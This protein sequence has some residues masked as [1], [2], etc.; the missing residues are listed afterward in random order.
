VDLASVQRAYKRYARHYDLL[1]GSIFDAGRRLSVRCVSGGGGRRILEVGVGT[2]LSL[3]YYPRDC[4]VVGVDV[5]RDMLEVARARAASERLH[6]VE[7]LLEMDAEQLD[8][9]DA[10]FDAVVAM[11]VATVVPDPARL[12]SEMCRVCVPGGDLVLVS[13]F[14]PERGPMRAVESALSPFSRVLGFRTAFTLDALRVPREVERVAV[15][16][17]NFLG[18]SKVVHYRR[19]ANGAPRRNGVPAR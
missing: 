3:R 17:V 14:A 10:S 19:T 1:W 11:Y 7:A 5:S 18:F 16:P 8:V 13:H 9:P 15:H 4:R 2:G 12:L 6:H